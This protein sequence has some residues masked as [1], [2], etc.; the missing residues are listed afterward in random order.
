MIGLCYNWRMHKRYPLLGARLFFGLLTLTAIVVQFTHELQHNRL[1]LV[2]FFSFFTI[3]SNILVALVFIFGGLYK[4]TSSRWALVRGAAAL[5]M[6]ITGL[7]YVALLSGLEDSL[8]T[9]VPWVNTTLH[10]LMPAVALLDW[11]AIRPVK[12]PFKSA[13]VW[14]VFPIVYLCY[15][16]VRGH[17]VG[18]YPYPFLNP[19]HHGYAGVAITSVGIAAIAIGLVFVFTLATRAPNKLDK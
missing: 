15:S 17:Y 5:Y 2:N 16:L 19:S 14:L 8:Q 13:L 10:Y 18:W 4:P 3:E 11:I 6:T 12:V 7:V 9:Q 1:N